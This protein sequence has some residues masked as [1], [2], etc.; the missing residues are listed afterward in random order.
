MQLV[1]ALEPGESTQGGSSENDKT[2]ARKERPGGIGARARL[3]EDELRHAPI[4]TRE[5]I[6]LIRAAVER[7]SRFSIPPRYMAPIQMKNS[8]AKLSSPFVAKW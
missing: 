4:G 6:A 5:E 8:S 7:A 2:P 3:Y 1:V